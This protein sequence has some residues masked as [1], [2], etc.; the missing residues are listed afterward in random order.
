MVS[1]YTV[2]R[3]AMK[4]KK[5]WY[6]RKLIA[7]PAFKENPLATIV[8]NKY[9]QRTMVDIEK[10]ATGIL[11]FLTTEVL[12]NKLKFIFGCYDINSDGYITNKELFDLLKL[13]N[14]GLISDVQLQNI[15]DKTFAAVGEY[16]L[17]IDYL[18][19]KNLL[20]SSNMNLI[21]LFNCI[22]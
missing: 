20:L 10:L 3:E 22:K 16:V 8:I 14:R 19:F 9:S 6:K 21:E 17:E 4:K 11:D 7:L 15:V 2:L 5:T 12:D 1:E 18:T 13:L